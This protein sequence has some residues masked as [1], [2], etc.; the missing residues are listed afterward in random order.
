MQILFQE[1]S[2]QLLENKTQEN[3]VAK[4]D[5]QS[6]L[7]VEKER[8]EKL[9]DSLIGVSNKLLEHK[10]AISYSKYDEKIEILELE[11][12]NPRCSSLF[13]GHPGRKDYDKH[14]AEI[15]QKYQLKIQESLTY[16]S[17][18]GNGAPPSDRLFRKTIFCGRNAVWGDKIIFL[19]TE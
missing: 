1:D 18:C 10:Y 11:R 3:Q 2:I 14:L 16:C 13:E 8:I 12:K 9:M 19:M 5:N 7:Y 17:F 15:R 4:I 6:K